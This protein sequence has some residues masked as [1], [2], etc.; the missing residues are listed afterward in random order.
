MITASRTEIFGVLLC[1]SNVQPSPDPAM[2]IMREGGKI[3]IALGN[4]YPPV[5]SCKLCGFRRAASHALVA[6]GEHEAFIISIRDFN[7]LL[8]SVKRD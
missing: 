4:D 5:S 7:A 3:T 8:R 1:C 6:D 2:V